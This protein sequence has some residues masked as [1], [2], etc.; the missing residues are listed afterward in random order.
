M[1]L[2]I[3]YIQQFKHFQRNARLFL[4]S[5]VLSGV[6]VGILLV[7]YNLYLISLGYHADFVGVVLFVGTIGAGLT[8]FPAGACIDRFSG[9]IILISSSTLI[10]IAGAGQILFRQPLPLLISSFIVGVGLAFLLVITAPFLTLNST[11]EER[12]HLFSMNI[13]LSLITLVLGE[14][15]GGVLPIWFQS[16]PWLMAPLPYRVSS[17]LAIQPDARSYQLA[18]LFAGVIALPSFIP[19]F[20]MSNVRPPRRTN[21]MSSLQLSPKNTA[22]EMPVYSRGASSRSPLPAFL[23]YTISLI[24]IFLH[25][26]FFFL[27]LVYV[28]TG[29]GAGLFIPYFNI[30]FVQHL[31]ASPALFGLIDGAANAITA[32]LTLTTPRLAKRLGK[33]NAITLTRLASIPLLLTIGLTSILPLAAFFYLFRQGTM[34][35][36]AGI[37]QVFSMESVA[38]KHRGLANSSYQAAFQVPWAV[39]A[40]IGGLIIVHFGY[41]PIFLLGAFFY[42]LTIIILW[43]RFGSRKLAESDEATQTQAVPL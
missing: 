28:L 11:P 9:K 5:N 43:A 38:E 10:G 26:A 42:I 3:E 34:D 7:L 4:I 1:R 8:I 27:V 40:P 17:L 37:L 21:H 13:S 18:L 39:A 2:V 24:N 12:P 16:I 32:L 14:V 35:M 36:S 23:S 25:S 29:F 19:L 30:Y 22:S 41:P 31:N 6:T 20:M 15:I 33:I